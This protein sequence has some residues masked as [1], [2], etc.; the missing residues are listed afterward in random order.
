MPLEAACLEATADG[1]LWAAKA[2]AL[3]MHA[4]GVDFAEEAV[5][6]AWI[7]KLA[8]RPA[9]PL[10]AVLAAQ[11]PGRGCPAAGRKA[12]RDPRWAAGHHCCASSSLMRLRLRLWAV[13]SHAR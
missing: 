7:A 11:A 8:E 4:D 5:V 6:A 3:A 9:P 1:P 10:R 13:R 2:I 12:G